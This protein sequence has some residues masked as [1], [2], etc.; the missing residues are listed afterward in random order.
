[1]HKA[2]LGQEQQARLS[3]SGLIWL[4]LVFI[5]IALSSDNFLDQISGAMSAEYK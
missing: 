2:L 5:L 4:K 3:F 1:M